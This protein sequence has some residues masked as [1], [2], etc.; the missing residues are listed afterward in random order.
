[1]WRKWGTEAAESGFSVIS[2]GARDSGPRS[3]DPMGSVS[4]E[5]DGTGGS[6]AREPECKDPVLE[7]AY[8][9]YGVRARR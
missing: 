1:M 2:E 3:G 9:L 8:R 7:G 6:D 5:P 4:T